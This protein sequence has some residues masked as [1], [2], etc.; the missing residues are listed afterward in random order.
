M[1]ADAGRRPRRTFYWTTDHAGNA[2][3]GQIGEA[4]LRVII[5]EICAEKW[6]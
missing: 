3:S 1:H 5:F 4:K 2:L 6:Q